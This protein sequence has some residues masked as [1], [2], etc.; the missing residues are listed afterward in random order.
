VDHA[1]VWSV[2]EVLISPSTSAE[3]VGG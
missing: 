3:P 2:G 1:P